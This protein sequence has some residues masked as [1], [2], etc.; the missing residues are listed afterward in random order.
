ME[1]F[2]SIYFW[3]KSHFE[4]D[5]SQNYSVF[6]PKYKYFEITPTTNTIFLAA[7]ELRCVGNKTWLKFNGSC[8]TQNRIKFYHKK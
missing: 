3:G 2:D 4:D 8:L 1:T 5:G 7:P 6:Q